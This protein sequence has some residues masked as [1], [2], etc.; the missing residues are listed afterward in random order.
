MHVEPG[1]TYS[2]T[3][4]LYAANLSARAVNAS[5]KAPKAT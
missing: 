1:V 2:Y 5:G 4:D 3:V